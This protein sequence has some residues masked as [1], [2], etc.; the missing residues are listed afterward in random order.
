M[1]RLSWV[2]VWEASTVCPYN[3]VLYQL[4]KLRTSMQLSQ[5][6]LEASSKTQTV[7]FSGQLQH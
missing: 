7:H 5:R 3:M 4:H 1:Y 2:L 6:F